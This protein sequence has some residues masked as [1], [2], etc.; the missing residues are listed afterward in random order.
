ML[1]LQTFFG[2]RSGSEKNISDPDSPHCVKYCTTKFQSF[3]DCCHS[4]Q[5]MTYQVQISYATK[6]N[7]ACPGM[8]YLQQI[9]V[10]MC[11]VTFREYESRW[12]GVGPGGA[13]LPPPEQ[14]QQQQPTPPPE[15][16]QQQPPPEQQQQQPPPPPAIKVGQHGYL[17]Q[18]RHTTV[19]VQLF[20]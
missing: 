10:L 7:T 19:G 16:Q 2:S 9:Y 6:D 8:M 11:Y 17:H 1:N 13:P 14:Q 12:A 3:T 18:P 15:Q 4:R 5:K 20:L